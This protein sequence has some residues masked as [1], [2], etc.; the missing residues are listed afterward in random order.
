MGFLAWYWRDNRRSFVSCYRG[1]K[2]EELSY[3]A[4]L[5]AFIPIFTLILAWIFLSEAPPAIGIIGILLVFLGVYVTNLTSKKIRWID[6]IVHVFKNSGARFGIGVSFSF[7]ASTVLIKSITNSG[8]KY[9]SVSIMLGISL[10]SWALT[11]YVPILKLKKLKKALSSH[12]LLLFGASSSNMLGRFFGILAIAGTFSSYA[13]S[14]RRL[15][16]IFTVLLGWQI[17][18]ETNIKNKLI[19]SALMTTGVAIIA[20]F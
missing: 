10:V 5:A 1:L 16:I 15:D 17:L 3:I 9:S 20:L 4:P 13:I 19:G 8:S 6:P 7:A 12:R 2:R 18:K 11:S 14:I